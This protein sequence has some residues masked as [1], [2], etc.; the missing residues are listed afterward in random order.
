MGY[1]GYDA[2]RGNHVVD[3]RRKYNDF[4]NAYDV[5]PDELTISEVAKILRCSRQMVLKICHKYKDL[6]Y[7]KVGKR[8]LIPKESVRDYILRNRG[9]KL[10]E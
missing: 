1:N 10:N 7:Y 9:G 6:P 5:Q 2:H 8:Y 3:E 4:L